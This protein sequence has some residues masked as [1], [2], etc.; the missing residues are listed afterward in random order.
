MYSSEGQKVWSCEL[1]SYGKVRNFQG[2]Y[3]TDC[4]F[5]YQGQYH[6]SETGLYYNR[7]RYYSPDEGVY[8]SQDLI[9]LKGGLNLYSYVLNTNNFIDIFGIAARVPPQTPNSQGVNPVAQRPSSIELQTRTDNLQGIVPESS[10]GYK[11]TAVGYA[12]DSNGNGY[13]VAASS[14]THLSPSQRAS[15]DGS[16]GEIRASGS[17]HAEVTIADYC[18]DNNLT[19]ESVAASR[20]VCEQCQNRLDGDGVEIVSERKKKNSLCS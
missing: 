8:I 18:R 17:E 16:Q 4:P 13:I 15:L 3:V 20:P 9:G 7:F 19:L 6:D 5:R 12:T 1:N 11:T 2:E 10:Q 14:D